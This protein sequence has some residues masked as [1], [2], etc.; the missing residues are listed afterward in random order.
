ML[1]YIIQLFPSLNVGSIIF[2]MYTVGY[3]KKKRK[4]KEKKK[5]LAPLKKYRLAA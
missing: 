4:K 1:F 5:K 3:N 2:F